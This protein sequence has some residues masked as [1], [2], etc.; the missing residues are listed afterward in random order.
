MGAVP[1]EGQSRAYATPAVNLEPGQAVFD[2]DI[3]CRES[4]TIAVPVS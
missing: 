3:R 2:G 4:V 1:R